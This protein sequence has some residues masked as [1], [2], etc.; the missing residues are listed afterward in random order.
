[1][2]NS[3]Q[4]EAMER[5]LDRRLG[6][7][8]D[9]WATV[10]APATLHNAIRE[11]L[12]AEAGQDRQNT[13]AFIRQLTQDRQLLDSLLADPAGL[14]PSCLARFKISC[15]EFAAELLRLKAALGTNANRELTDD[16]L[17]CVAGGA[18]TDGFNLH[19]IEELL[20]FIDQ[21]NLH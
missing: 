16:E 15:G 13:Q 3:Q 21:T 8:A 11:A 9:Q 12:Q 10:T 14:L 6:E 2:T 4:N 18:S 19:D 1:M 7:L 17:A 5:A 20:D